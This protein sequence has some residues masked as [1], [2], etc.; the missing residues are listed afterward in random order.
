M[1]L[2]VKTGGT[3]AAVGG[4]GPVPP[5]DAAGWQRPLDWPALPTVD[6]TEQKVVGLV[7]V[8]NTTAEYL[9]VLFRDAYTVDWG[10][11]VVENFA[12]NVKAEHQYTYASIPGSPTTDGWK[13]VT[14]TITPQAGN[15]LTLLNLRQRYGTTFA[16]ANNWLDIAISGPN[17]T[18]FA[19]FSN[20]L[21][22]FLGP[23]RFQ[24]LSYGGTAFNT[25]AGL[26]LLS[27][28]L[29]DIRAPSVV[30]LGSTPIA[31]SAATRRARFEF[32]PDNTWSGGTAAFDG[33]THLETLE[34]LNLGSATVAF[35]GLNGTS[36]GSRPLR[37]ILMHGYTRSL[38]I[39]WTS[40]SAEALNACFT[41]LGTAAEGA[42]VTITGCPGAETCDQTIATAKGWSVTN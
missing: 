18:H 9:A 7:G 12:D 13:I 8:G 11:G 2:K 1:A 30:S 32:S 42:V 28:N 36:G 35:T 22:G 20:A 19:P 6:P 23:R 24:L 3:F 37:S 33:M 26:R 4:S 21:L 40:L 29:F 14:V 16:H 17:L 15:N 41:A 25:N 10:D 27:A 31:G 5:A 39:S 34:V 38:N